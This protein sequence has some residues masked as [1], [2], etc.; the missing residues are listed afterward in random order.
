MEI[1]VVALEPYVHD[2]SHG[3]GFLPSSKFIPGSVG[4]D[5]APCSG[6]DTHQAL[7][8]RTH[9][10]ATFP[11][12]CTSEATGSPDGG[13]KQRKRS[14][15]RAQFA[16]SS[17]PDDSPRRRLCLVL[18]RDPSSSNVVVKHNLSQGPL[19]SRRHCVLRMWFP[20]SLCHPS[21]MRG[22]TSSTS[23]AFAVDCVD[24]GSV[25]GTFVNGRKAP[26]GGQVPPPPSKPII[27]DAEALLQQQ[28]APVGPGT[29]YGTH[30][31]S[32]S[33][34]IG[35]KVNEGGLL[36]PE[37][38]RLRFDVFVR[39]LAPAGN[40]AQRLVW[41]L[42]HD[43]LPV[44]HISA[45]RS[46]LTTT[47]S[48]VT[49]HAE[50][51]D[52][53]EKDDQ[54]A[55]VRC[56]Q[57]REPVNAAVASLAQPSMTVSSPTRQPRPLLLFAA[58]SSALLS[59]QKSNITMG[60]GELSNGAMGGNKSSYALRQRTDDVFSSI[61]K[62]HGYTSLQQSG[63]LPN[64][65]IS[66]M[67][68]GV[69]GAELPRQELAAAEA[70]VPA[71]HNVPLS[72][73]ASE[74][75]QSIAPCVAP[76]SA[77]FPP[78]VSSSSSGE[79]S[80]V[81]GSLAAGR[82]H[83]DAASNDA[84]SDLHAVPCLPSSPAPVPV[85]ERIVDEVEPAV[86]LRRG[87]GLGRRPFHEPPLALGPSNGA[88]QHAPQVENTGKPF[89]MIALSVDQSSM[90]LSQ[91]LSQ[92]DRESKEHQAAIA[93]N[94]Q[95]FG[96]ALDAHQRLL[97][98][99]GGVVPPK[100][101]DVP[102]QMVKKKKGRRVTD[103]YETIAR[104]CEALRE[105]G[106]EAFAVAAAPPSDAC[107]KGLAM[108]QSLKASLRFM[109]QMNNPTTEEDKVQQDREDD[110]IPLGK[111]VP[112]RH[113]ARGSARNNSEQE[114]VA[115]SVQP[116]EP[117]SSWNH[118]DEYIASQLS[119]SFDGVQSAG[120]CVLV[121]GGCHVAK[122][123]VE[124]AGNATRHATQRVETLRCLFSDDEDGDSQPPP[125]AMESKQPSRSFGHL[126]A[127]ASA[128]PRVLGATPAMALPPA[129]AVREA[130]KAS[131]DGPPHDRPPASMWSDGS[132]AS[133]SAASQEALTLLATQ[134]SPKSSCWT[135]PTVP[136]QMT[137]ARQLPVRRVAVD[138]LLQQQQP[139]SLW[140]SPQSTTLAPKQQAEPQVLSIPLSPTSGNHFDHLAGACEPL[141]EEE[142]RVTP[143]KDA[144]PGPVRRVTFHPT[145]SMIDLSSSGPT[146]QPQHGELR[147]TGA[148]LPL[149][150]GG[151]RPSAA[152]VRRA[153]LE[154]ALMALP[155]SSTV[156]DRKHEDDSTPQ[157]T[158]PARNELQLATSWDRTASDLLANQQTASSEVD[159][160]SAANRLINNPRGGGAAAAIATVEVR[161]ILKPHQWDAL[162][163]LWGCLMF[164]E[165]PLTAA[166]PARRS[167]EE[168]ESSVSAAVVKSSLK[169]KRARTETNPLP[170]GTT[171]SG[172]EHDQYPTLHRASTNYNF[173]DLDSNGIPAD[174]Q[175]HAAAAAAAGGRPRGCVIAHAMGLGKSLS[176]IAFLFSLW[177][178][179]RDHPG[180][181]EGGGG[182]PW[183]R[184]LHRSGGAHIVLCVP[185]PLVCHWI[186]EF[187]TWSTEMHEEPVV[188]YLLSHETKSDKLALIEEW[189]AQGSS[190]SQTSMDENATN[191]TASCHRSVLL[192]THSTLCSIMMSQQDEASVSSTQRKKKRKPPSKKMTA[193]DDDEVFW[194]D[195]ALEAAEDEA[196]ADASEA[197]RQLRFQNL[198]ACREVLLKATNCVILDEAHKLQC[199]S[200]RL[201]QS[202]SMFRGHSVMK[203]ALTGTPVT[204]S[205]RDELLAIT[206]YVMPS[207]W[208]KRD[209]SDRSLLAEMA[210]FVHGKGMETL[211]AELPKIVEHTVVVR[212][213]PVQEECFRGLIHAEAVHGVVPPKRL[214]ETVS[215]TM[216]ISNHLDL[217]ADWCRRRGIEGMPTSEEQLL[218]IPKDVRW[219]VPS[220]PV[221]SI[222]DSLPPNDNNEVVGTAVTPPAV[223]SLQY[224][225]KMRVLVVLLQQ[226]LARN[227]KVVVFSH[228]VKT[229]F[230]IG[231]LL[232][233]AFD[234]SDGADFALLDG[235]IP[236]AVRDDI[237]AAFNRRDDDDDNRSNMRILLLSFQSNSVGQNFTGA[238]RV[239]LFES[240]WRRSME[241][242]AICRVFRYGQRQN[243]FV[244]RLVSLNGVEEK[245]MAQRDGRNRNGKRARADDAAE[246]PWSTSVGAE[247]LL[248]SL[249][250]R[251]T[252]RHRFNDDSIEDEVLFAVVSGAA[253]VADVH[254]DAS[255][256]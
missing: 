221:P 112:P 39:I 55:D 34:G 226:A 237:T 130:S 40:D 13:H 235:R 87:G 134:Q 256:E 151:G 217:V 128:A 192:V 210:R 19:L 124:K 206:Q 125:V 194:C 132:C 240:S 42:F 214:L 138:A 241:L 41:E 31:F 62:D 113:D 144:G 137:L 23:I 17:P 16:C 68:Q 191:S 222:F 5:A 26:A 181:V 56:D 79:A 143:V 163:F 166:A 126:R 75:V 73:A 78:H 149:R 117:P 53:A 180:G 86:L 160:S 175:Q 71:I 161:S 63:N 172:T 155:A 251:S 133:W 198:H 188:V 127:H 52:D 59:P 9:Y 57:T 61:L 170:E 90:P 11:S 64:N 186:R 193:G 89:S 123:E 135:Q 98:K 69:T 248:H 167:R 233:V 231:K 8:A 6:A 171:E 195:E 185:K 3:G 50:D 249:V 147:V 196:A 115:L 252:R 253:S 58:K 212:M 158:H 208:T 116:K 236:G 120:G 38:E 159:V 178:Y 10:V 174:E 1:S 118:V 104:F 211:A 215:R 153:K 49:M 247:E 24:L 245:I 80:F 197:K 148:A 99:K 177:R 142:P 81:P 228:S 220:L 250:P 15:V 114:A 168:V 164:E 102:P 108:A 14:V 111:L 7:P 121:A 32:L 92:E 176:T 207:L 225:W 201:T 179:L 229:L 101:P 18:G 91:P 36:P 152:T 27:V 218:R 131:S 223:E 224:S 146:S 183:L 209:L 238:Q 72:S 100:A 33:F 122:E 54:A 85:Q 97:P 140:A 106:H 37:Q 94:D 205:K 28:R 76:S 239:I 246:T 43:V 47:T 45:P 25:N 66:S 46:S 30:V 232:S 22:G 93:T 141:D 35:S 48:K 60:G 255:F 234:F 182:M 187:H 204:S 184:C 254:R 203:I 150:R 109:A 74:V 21:V 65:N 227:E 96:D 44:H 29:E 51:E 200:S 20:R 70:A 213:S 199:P 139:L 77:G 2:F 84:P 4:E 243:V 219:A 190:S 119:A 83:G 145:V 103:P 129:E 242:Q 136:S 107:D 67:V 162:R 82:L 216:L 165:L 88:V 169:K 12:S 157:V 173:A 156:V 202:V 95:L 154:A 189:A 230:L 110:D 105:E 244:N